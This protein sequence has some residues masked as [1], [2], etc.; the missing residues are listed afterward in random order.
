MYHVNCA[1]TIFNNEIVRGVFDHNHEKLSDVIIK[2]KIAQYEE[3]ILAQTTKQP[4]SQIHS[5]IQSK[6]VQD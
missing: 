2:S 5:E 4:L 3:K 1:L 6:F